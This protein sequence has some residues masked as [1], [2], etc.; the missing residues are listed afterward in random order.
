[1]KGGNLCKNWPHYPIDIDGGTGGLVG[2][3][4]MICGGFGGY[5]GSSNECYSLTS[6][7]S[8][9]VTHMS[10]ARASAV[11][12][13][14]NDTT[15]W[16]T[17]GNGMDKSTEFVTITGITPG[18]DMPIGVTDYAMVANNETISMLIGGFG[19]YYGSNPYVSTFYYNHN[20]GEWI[21][22]PSLLQGRYSHAAGIV[23]DKVTNEYLVAV[24]GGHGAYDSTEFLLNDEWL[25]GNIITI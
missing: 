10:V 5:Y 11:S 14:L 20:K 13:A 7:K 9:F 16:V 8:T 23:P 18:P 4:I 12:I 2:N 1:M 22:G 6:Q 19:G 25:E 21:S 3:N 17:G 15:L 24:T